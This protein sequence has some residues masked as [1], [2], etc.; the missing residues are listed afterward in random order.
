M[1]S[2]PNALDELA[3]ELSL[4]ALERQERVL[5]ELR[6]RTGVLLAASSLA[7]S[8]LGARAADAGSGVLT[9]A[10][11]AAFVISIVLMALVL[12]PTE[13]LSSASEGRRCSKQSGE[14]PRA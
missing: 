1:S 7:A 12:M 10:A 14:T 5:D 6:G 4:R 3:Y 2:L 8:F 11:L 13:R 9:F